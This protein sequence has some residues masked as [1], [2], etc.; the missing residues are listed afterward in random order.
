MDDLRREV[1]VMRALD[2]P[3]LVKL[4]EVIEDKEGGKLLMVMEYCEAGAL[5]GP[6]TLTPERHLPEAMAQYYFR[7]MASG[8][9][10]LHENHVVHGDVK[11]ENVM[12]SGNGTVKIG[13]FGQSQFFGRRDVFNRTLGTP[14]YLAPEVCA[15]ES[16]RG[17]QADIWALGVSL[18]L[19]I[20]GE[21]PFKGESVLDLY[22]AIAM[23]EV[24]YPRSQPISYELQDLFLR[25]LHKDPR[26]RITAAEVMQHPW[27]SG[28]AWMALAPDMSLRGSTRAVLEASPEYRDLVESMAHPLASYNAEE[29][30]AVVFPEM[31]DMQGSSPGSPGAG[32]RTQLVDSLMAAAMTGGDSSGRRA[33]SP[34]TGRL[35]GLGEDSAVMEMWASQ[36]GS[37]A[38]AEA[39]ADSNAA[40][41]EAASD[42][43]EP[44][45]SAV[46]GREAAAVRA[47]DRR[48]ATQLSQL[49][50][51]LQRGMPAE[52]QQQQ[53]RAPAAP[54]PTDEIEPAD[55]PVATQ[56][57]QQQPGAAQHPAAA[58]LQQRPASGLGRPPLPPAMQ[59]VRRDS[60]TPEQGRAMLPPS[61]FGDS[62]LDAFLQQEERQLRAAQAAQAAQQ[63]QQQAQRPT[64]GDSGQWAVLDHGGIRSSCGAA[65]DSK[66]GG[67][68]KAASL[69][70]AL[71]VGPADFLD[72][73]PVEGAPAATPAAAAAANG[74]QHR[75]SLDLKR[76]SSAPEPQSPRQ[77]AASTP[78]PATGSA[79]AAQAKAAPRRSATFFAG[80]TDFIQADGGPARAPPRPPMPR[81]T[82][83]RPIVV[84][85]YKPGDKM[86]AASTAKRMDFCSYIEQGDVSVRYEADVPVSLSSV[87]SAALPWRKRH[88][89]PPQPA[90]SAS[91]SPA[92]AA[93]IHRLSSSVG[94]MP[95]SALSTVASQMNTPRGLPPAGSQGTAVSPHSLATTASERALSP[96]ASVVSPGGS[97]LPASSSS[98]CMDVWD[99][100]DSSMHDSHVFDLGV[101]PDMARQG[102][103]LIERSSTLAATVHHAMQRAEALL[104]SAKAGSVDHLLVAERTAG[105]FLGSLAMLDPRFFQGRWKATAVA[106]T[107]VVVLAMTREGLEMFL[108]QNPLA[109]VHL[110]A[111]MARARAEV[112][113]LEALEKIAQAHQ[114]SLQRKARRARHHAARQATARRLPPSQP[115]KLGPGVTGVAAG[116]A[117]AAAA[118]VSGEAAAPAEAAEQAA[119]QAAE[120]AAGVEP[121]GAEA[122]TAAQAAAAEAEAE[123]AA[124]AEADEEDER[125]AALLAAG[126]SSTTLEL[127]SVVTRMR[128]ALQESLQERLSER[129]RLE[130]AGSSGRR[131]SEPVPIGGRR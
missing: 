107:H 83:S 91:G 5:V 36:G 100:A 34:C 38:G 63:P 47:A 125:M 129:E 119:A 69:L 103:E 101:P 65:G 102:S 45:P 108:Q 28:S 70:R 30:A 43:A 88:Q 60:L 73:M 64:S 113:K 67:G 59:P 115:S 13:D 33:Q 92:T 41:S 32:S 9:A 109:Q 99:K 35:H 16:Y 51:A 7:Q 76:A 6:G 27:V 80:P 110:R 21:L 8:L 81:P 131:T 123:A 82:Q 11:P 77:Q 22:D 61:P 15:G 26:Y 48:R 106:R 40:A 39:D 71:F 117:A 127:F 37:T 79:A 98:Y 12:L 89:H 18:Y 74:S 120:A 54:T 24:P 116:A 66:P 53:R 55:E 56:H 104:T 75:G 52:Q 4:Y 87:L 58:A 20:F 112:V 23:E 130:A 111:S 49:S 10:Y 85:I 42:P 128:E 121:P 126:V 94:A 17:R 3:N 97:A 29:V 124:E 44:P 86:G 68:R 105:E 72:T 84:Q 114:Q 1:E 50:A 62:P 14:A 19:F 93:P 95:Q 96:G 78:A 57:R 31:A 25:L 2:H 118:G 90:H 122:E 46:G